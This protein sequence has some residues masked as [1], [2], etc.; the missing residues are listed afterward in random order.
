M[1]FT[2]QEATWGN[3]VKYEVLT[4]WTGDY[5]TDILRPI[6]H[7]TRTARVCL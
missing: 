3:H 4:C 1:L 2:S 5:T 7:R 6:C